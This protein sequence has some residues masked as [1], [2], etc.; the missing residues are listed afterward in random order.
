MKSD[1]VGEL[2]GVSGKRAMVTG[3]ATGIGLAI[4]TAL[5]KAG[6]RV[7]VADLNEQGARDAAAWLGGGAIGLGIDVRDR[8]SVERAFAEVLGAF[9]GCE[10]L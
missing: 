4:A 6:A 8:N 7:A 1:R 2:D 5:A 3:G 10:I 9:G